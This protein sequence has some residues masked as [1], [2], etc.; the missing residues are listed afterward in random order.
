MAWPRMVVLLIQCPAY[1]HLGDTLVFVRPLV[2]FYFTVLICFD[3][4]HAY[5]QVCTAAED[6]CLVLT[7]GVPAVWLSSLLALSLRCPRHLTVAI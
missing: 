2:Y 3:V 4:P 7:L 1:V 5:V 6:H